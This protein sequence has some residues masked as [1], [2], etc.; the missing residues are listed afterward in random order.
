MLPGLLF[1]RSALT[2]PK[3]KRD[4]DGDALSRA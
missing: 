4:D 1:S 3:S 2:S